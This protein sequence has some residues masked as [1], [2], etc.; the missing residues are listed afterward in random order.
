LASC[1]E[2]LGGRAGLWLEKLAI[3]HFDSACFG[4]IFCDFGIIL[5]FFSEAVFQH[6]FGIVFHDFGIMFLFILASFRNH[7]CVCICI[8]RK[9]DFGDRHKGNQWF[10]LLECAPKY[11]KIESKTMSETAATKNHQ[12]NEKR[13]TKGGQK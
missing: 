4:S 5:A 8:P 7:F 9:R 12:N 1:G 13:P 10:C 11:D 2:P 3:P 6:G